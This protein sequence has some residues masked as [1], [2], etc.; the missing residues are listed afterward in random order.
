[1]KKVFEEKMI[2][3]IKP[4]KTRKV[5]KKLHKQERFVDEINT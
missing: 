5:R 4:D 3:K 1:M 2:R